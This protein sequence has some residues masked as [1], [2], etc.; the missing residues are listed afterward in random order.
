[1]HVI[2][3]KGILKDKNE[4]TEMKMERAGGVFRIGFSLE[5]KV[6]KG[7]A[8]PYPNSYNILCDISLLT[9]SSNRLV[10]H[11]LKMYIHG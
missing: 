8:T 2:E 11:H 3:G 7:G 4:E 1:M 6:Q 10:S 9:I 5:R